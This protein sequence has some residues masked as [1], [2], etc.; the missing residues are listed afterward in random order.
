MRALPVLCS[1]VLLSGCGESAY[2]AGL[3][4][5]ADYY[6]HVAMLDANLAK[7]MLFGG[8]GIPVKVR[9][10][11]QFVPITPEPLPLDENGNPTEPPDGQLSPAEQVQPW[12]LGVT[13][14]GVAGAW[15]VQ[16]MTDV[17]G[18][19]VGKPAFL[20]LLSSEVLAAQQRAADLGLGAPPE[21]PPADLLFETE[22]RLA[23]AFGVEIPAGDAGSVEN[24]N[25]RYLERYPRNAAMK[26]YHEAKPFTEIRF[27]PDGVVEQLEVPYKFHLYEYEDAGSG[28]QLAFFLVAPQGVLRQE[29]LAK[30]MDLML[31]TMELQTRGGA[32][33]SSF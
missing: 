22:A 7:P 12:Y 4:R 21:V 33:P 14:P 2:R 5:T 31:T 11:I 18:E 13:L 25:E 28:V 1:L 17:G 3:A 8:D 16:V 10:P 29:D 24:T 32:R 23:A 9:A 6:A 19:D 30:R 27:Q 26:Q 20:Y 15:S